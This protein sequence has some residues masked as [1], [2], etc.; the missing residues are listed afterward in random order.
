VGTVRLTMA[1]A[2]VRFLANQYTERDGVDQRFF[3]GCFG[4]FGHGNVA[5]VGQA[6]QQYADR[7]T[8]YQARNEQAMVHTASAYARQKNRLQTLACTTSIGP[9]ATNMVTGAALATINR[10]PVLLLPGDVFASRTPD[11]VLQQLEAPHDG[12]HSVN[13]CFRPVSRYW[14]RIDRPEQLIPSALAAMRVLTNQAET[15]AVTLALPQDVQAEAYDFP[16]EFFERRVWHIGRP[17]PDPAE[18]DRAVEFIRNSTRPMIVAGG[19]VIYSG[20]ADAL[21]RFAE[22]TGIPVGETQAGKGSMPYDHP[23]S[24]GAV[25]A[26]GTFAANR[27]ANEAD[28]VIGVGTRWTDFTTASKTAFQN[29]E[30]RF[31]NVNIADFDAAKHAGLR[32]VGDARATLE[33]LWEALAGY[34]VS[35]EYREQNARLNEEWDHEV[36]R[37]YALDHG[38]LPAQSEVIG[39]VNSFSEAGDVVVCAAGSMPGDLHK[40]WRTRDLKGYHVEYGYSCMGYEIAGGLGI[41][42]ATPEREVYVMV[43]DGSYLMMS[44]E[45]ITSIQEGYKLTIVL[46]DNA[47]FSSIGALSRSVGSQGFGTHY[48]Y[49]KGGSIG[50]DSEKDPGEV[51][52]VD[53]ATNAQSFGARVFR[54][55]T[56]G[57]LND[58][59][60]KAKGEDRTVV[61]HVPVDRYEGVPS[62]ESFWDV[63]VAEISEMDSVVAARKEYAANKQAERRYL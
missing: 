58:A 13:D 26:T 16:E 34:E 11:P 21:R 33:A 38:P 31:I 49:R 20:A 8:Y 3:A 17:L 9:G 59:L 35:S 32:L 5:G 22:Q 18:L 43:G 45:I 62:Y 15:G 52:P 24:L 63:P 27:V 37:L 41:K 56:I 51:L 55:K 39:A 50:L 14:D 36:G 1:Q 28:V 30:V 4:I 60:A 19:G 12:T 53:L 6:L 61:I 57:D 2:L 25:G 47:G 48:R 40:L 29:P 46:V 42:M 7:I 44:S 23:C 54:T 10:L